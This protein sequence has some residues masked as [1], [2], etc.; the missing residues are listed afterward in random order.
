MA[1]CISET[2]TNHHREPHPGPLAG[3]IAL[4]RVWRQRYRARGELA[5][6]TDRDFHD[7]G[8]SW[9]DYAYEANKPFWRA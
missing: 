7:V 9:S 3:L 6:L 8:A 1:A 4:L 2:M 5:R